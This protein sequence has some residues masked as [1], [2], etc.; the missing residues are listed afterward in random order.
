MTMN[1]IC[2]PKIDADLKKCDAPNLEV[3]NNIKLKTFNDIDIKPFE[4]I[5][6]D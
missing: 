6:Q 4:I 3:L 2:L 1:K 5:D